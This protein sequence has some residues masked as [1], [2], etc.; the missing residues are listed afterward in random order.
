VKISQIG[1]NLSS[2]VAIGEPY[3]ENDQIG[4]VAPRQRNRIGDVTTNTANIV[5][6]LGERFHLHIGNNQVI[7]GYQ[8]FQN[9][10]L[11]GRLAILSRA[12]HRLWTASTEQ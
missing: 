9:T 10:P 5:P 3:V 8:D 1:G 4:L 2:Q 6:V 7:F 11:L 12:L